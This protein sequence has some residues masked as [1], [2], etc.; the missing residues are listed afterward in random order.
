MEEICQ[1]AGTTK[2]AFFHHFETKQK[3]GLLALDR[4]ARHLT[5]EYQAGLPERSSDPVERLFAYVDRVMEVGGSVQPFPS[6]L[7]GLLTL[8]LGA[9]HSEFRAAAN[10]AFGRWLDQLE[11]LI[12]DAS[13]KVNARE[14]AEL[15][16]ATLQG[17]LI[18]ARARGD[19]T[20]IE[21]SL[22]AFKR[23]FESV[24]R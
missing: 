9:A 19:A 6:C 16:L 23:Y 11:A 7:V 4:F 3:A 1:R 18:L 24:G 10:E 17:A 8:E 12:A 13:P 20:V 5:A 2:G 21:T 14:I 22:E 15:F